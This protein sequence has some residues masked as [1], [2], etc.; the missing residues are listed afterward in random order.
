[1]PPANCRVTPQRFVDELSRPGLRPP[2]DVY[3]HHPYPVRKPTDKNFAGATYVDL[4][5]LPVLFRRMDAGYLRGKRVWVTE[6]GVATERT[7]QQPYFRVPEEQKGQLEDALRRVE[8]QR[9][10]TLFVWYF[11]Q[12]NDAWKS[13]LYNVDGSPKPALAAFEA[14]ARGR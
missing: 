13:G 10:V 11:M 7:L 12:D 5:N 4:Y 2:M 14:A 8:A 6:F 3:A 9:R 1:V